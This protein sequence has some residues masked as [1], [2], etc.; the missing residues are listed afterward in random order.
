MG[1]VGENTPFAAL[2]DVPHRIGQLFPLRSLVAAA[3]VGNE[4]GTNPRT[5]SPGTIGRRLVSHEAAHAAYAT[6]AAAHALV[7]AVLELL[8]LPAPQT[9]VPVL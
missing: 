4:V 5:G 2:R 1:V 6:H 7:I 3:R 9:A 8:D